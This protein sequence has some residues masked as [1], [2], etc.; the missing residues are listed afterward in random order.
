MCFHWGWEL[1]TIDDPPEPGRSFGF[2][3]FAWPSSNNFSNM[4]PTLPPLLSNVSV[5]GARLSSHEDLIF[6]LA[7]LC[8]QGYLV[9]FIWET[10]S[11]LKLLQGC[12]KTPLII[13]TIAA[14]SG[15]CGLWNVC[16]G[17][18][19]CH[20]LRCCGWS[21]AVVLYIFCKFRC[22]V[23]PKIQAFASVSNNP[24][25]PLALGAAYSLKAG[26]ALPQ[27]RRNHI[28]PAL[29]VVS[30][31][32]LHFLFSAL[33]AKKEKKKRFPK[34]GCSSVSCWGFHWRSCISLIRE[35][36]FRE[37]HHDL[38][39]GLSWTSKRVTWKCFN[40]G[41]VCNGEMSSNFTE[42]NLQVPHTCPVSD[43]F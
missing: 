20:V 31:W 36:M 5:K 38:C 41:T 28:A 42:P 3:G 23:K 40:L 18:W 10:A 43:G 14:F 7:L 25:Q 39:R 29:A 32:M 6:L 19:S 22:S 8:F 17:A 34:Q 11:C 2:A 9:G 21:D 4:K 15:L 26:F 33:L 16:V 12:Q 1:E 13:H 27:L 30:G 24:A 37:Y 35:M